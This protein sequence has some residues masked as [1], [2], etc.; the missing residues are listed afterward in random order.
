M[1]HL[2][3]LC[4]VK[5]DVEFEIQL[6]LSVI[7]KAIISD[8]SRISEFTPSCVDI[9][10]NAGMRSDGNLKILEMILNMVR[11][12]NSLSEKFNELRSTQRNINWELVDEASE[13]LTDTSPA[14][15]NNLSER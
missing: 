15:G 4:Q 8:S 9:L 3:N 6:V 11:R 10:A 14:F 7:M 5:E 12:E 13:N 2:C 1:Q